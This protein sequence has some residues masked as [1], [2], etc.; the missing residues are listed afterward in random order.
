MKYLEE[1]GLRAR[2]AATKLNV[3]GQEE[4]NN[5]LR[6]C[7]KA[8]L[9]MEEIILKA[10]ETDVTNAKNN[11][12]KESL[13]DRLS[14]TH[15]RIVS[16]AEGLKEITG[17]DDPIGEIISMK[18]RPNGL[19]IGQKR[20]PLGVVGIIYESRPNVTADAFGLCFKT[21]NAVILRGGSDAIHSN[22][23]IVNVIQKA[24]VKV[25]LPGDSVILIEDTSR[26]TATE[27]MK[28]N[29]Y[30]DVLIPRG[31]EGL[32]KSVVEN[33]TIPVIET[34]TGNCHIYVDEFADLDMAVNIIIN[35]KT[36]RLGVC[37]ACE[38]LVVH[39]SVAKEFIPQIVEALT[40]RNVEIRGDMDSRVLSA[41]IKEAAEEDWG[42]EYLDSII[43]LK[44]VNSI[45]EGI[46]HINKYNTKHSEAIITKDYNNSMKFLNEI[47]AAAVY[48]NASTRFTDGFEFGFGAEIGIS[49]QKLHARGPMGLLALTTTKYIIFGNGQIRP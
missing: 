48:V 44:I 33:S 42:R 21:G 7:A 39:K 6:A 17:L 24:L 5:G 11:G 41:Q 3:L 13:I 35:A 34:G 38:S 20:V 27:L 45:E 28:L 12:V 46:S 14:L 4:K 15:E 32:I 9:E 25:S 23:A 37:N 36:Q 49:T 19:S 2:A 29:K 43:S 10:N 31:G 40:L 16:M 1:I 8:L 30:I 47:D 18:N 22:K 26:E